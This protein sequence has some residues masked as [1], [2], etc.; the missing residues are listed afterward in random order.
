MAKASGDIIKRHVQSQAERR[1]MSKIYFFLFFFTFILVGLIFLVHYDRLL[2]KRISVTGNQV[3]SS[4]EIFA[5]AQEQLVGNYFYLLPKRNIFFLPKR[6][7]EEAVVSRMPYVRNLDSEVLESGVFNL[8]VTE[9]EPAALWCGIDDQCSFIDDTGFVFSFAPKFSDNV[10]LK[11]SDHTGENQIGLRPIDGAKFRIIF[12]TAETLPIVLKESGLEKAEVVKVM[13]TKDKDY[14]FIITQPLL[15]E[16]LIWT[17]RLPPN[18]E[19]FSHLLSNLKAALT[20][21]EFKKSYD[22]SAGRL[23]YVDLR[24]GN[25]V[26]YKFR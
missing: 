1:R 15:N 12:L 14:D 18:Q 17:L 23:D 24:F 25:K 11:L 9:R 16:K 4:D 20:A 8:R 21:P 3:V 26:F 19:N 2:V 6:R 13:I 5:L 10:Y 22:V 7:I